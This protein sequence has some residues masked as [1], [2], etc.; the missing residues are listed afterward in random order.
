MA[1]KNLNYNL[2]DEVAVNFQIGSNNSK[3]GN[4]T[5]VWFIPKDMI[6]AGKFDTALDCAVCFDCPHSQGNGCYVAKGN[7][8]RGLGS[9]IRSMNKGYKF[10]GKDDIINAID[11]F[12]RFG[13]YGEPILL[14][15]DMVKDI[16]DASTNWTGY[17]HQWALYPEYKDYFMASV[18]NL[19]EAMLAESLGWRWFLVLEKDANLPEGFELDGLKLKYEGQ[20][21]AINCPASKESGNKAQCNT[22]GLCKGASSK[23]KNIWIY[24]H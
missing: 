23:A 24:K 7:S 9:K 10:H 19:T 3:V 16:T 21:V 2:N 18:D 11:G 4:S 17:T 1:N 5:Q 20:T 8:A 12:V 14:P 15:L 6:E 13:A 22:C